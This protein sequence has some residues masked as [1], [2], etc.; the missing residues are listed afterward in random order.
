MKKFA[1]MLLALV[2]ACVALTGAMAE[3]AVDPQELLHA[4]SGTYTE[5]FPVICAPEYDDVWLDRSAEYAGEEYAEMVAEILKSACTGEIMG[6]E[7]V[8]A[9]TA[10]PDS[11]VFDCYFTNGVSLFVFDGDVVRG[12]DE[13]GNV[14]FEHTYTYAG[15]L[16]GSLACYMYKTEDADAGEFTYICLA[17]DTPDT[18]FHI[19]F[20]YGDDPE[21]LNEMTEGKYAY[22]MAAGIPVDADEEMIYNCID[23]F[24]AENSPS[25]EE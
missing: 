25:D 3:E 24:A 7:A 15:M 16:E 10:D 20:R 21:A 14:V 4:V 5:L 1:S 9:Y 2:L 11:A 13:E 18:T 6:Q 19:E 23:L 8:D 17:P 12:L 22:W